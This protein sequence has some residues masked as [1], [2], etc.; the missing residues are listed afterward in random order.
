[1]PDN[2]QRKK[3]VVSATLYGDE[4]EVLDRWAKDRLWSRNKA[5]AQLIRGAL[6]LDGPS[7]EDAE[8]ET[9]PDTGEKGQ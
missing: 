5:A 8:D 9:Q 1:M 3:I 7:V 4:V 2:E 6:D